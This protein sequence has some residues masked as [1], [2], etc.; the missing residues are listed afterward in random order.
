MTVGTLLG[1]V[2]EVAT[3]VSSIFDT[4]TK[5]INML[6][7]Y[8]S[9]AAEKQALRSIVDT[10]GF[11]ERLVEEKTMETVTRKLEIKSFCSQSQHHADLYQ[12]TYNEFL[13]L[14]ENT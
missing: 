6:N 14:L 11:K 3:S 2:N 4:A 10:H 1:T 5:S 7:R 12:A 9:E 8:V 13:S